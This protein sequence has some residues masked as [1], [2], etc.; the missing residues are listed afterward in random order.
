MFVQDKLN[1]IL[2]EKAFM[3]DFMTVT[4]A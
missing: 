3:G 1:D 2:S 4:V